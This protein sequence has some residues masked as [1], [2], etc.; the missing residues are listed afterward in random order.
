[1]EQGFAR[2][3]IW[4]RKRKYKSIVNREIITLKASIKTL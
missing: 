3:A 1:M 4:G 2:F